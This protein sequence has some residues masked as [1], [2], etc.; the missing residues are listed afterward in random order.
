MAAFNR[1][2]SLLNLATLGNDALN[3][4]TPW[5]WGPWMARVHTDRAPWAGPRW[6][7]KTGLSK[8]EW[9]LVRGFVAAVYDAG[10]ARSHRY[11]FV[12]S[13]SNGPLFRG[14]QILQKKIDGDWE[15]AGIDREVE[16]ILRS[17]GIEQ[18]STR[19]ISSRTWPQ[20]PNS[21]TKLTLHYVLGARASG[22]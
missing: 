21:C 18:V 9:A 22:T 16:T 10:D 19:A 17:M 4:P 15:R 11:T 1:L 14:F 13:L 20:V 12:S 6:S 3:N 5:S 7:A 2:L 8:E